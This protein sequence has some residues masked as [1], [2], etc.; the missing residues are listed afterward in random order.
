MLFQMSPGENEILSGWW[1]T[2]VMISAFGPP[3]AINLKRWTALLSFHN[4]KHH[5]VFLELNIL[6]HLLPVMRRQ[7][8]KVVL[9]YH[10][11]WISGE[12]VCFRL[13]MCIKTYIAF[14][15]NKHQSGSM[16]YLYLPWHSIKSPD[17]IAPTE[18]S[19]I[20]KIYLLRSVTAEMQ[21][22]KTKNA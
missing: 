3:V 5:F 10:P 8:N 18:I 21:R 11:F 6:R 22:H 19:S 16:L 12:R 1:N 7:N 14:A 20:K 17:K 4:A 15:T 9:F 13:F 2:D